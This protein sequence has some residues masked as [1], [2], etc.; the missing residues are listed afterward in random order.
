MS[1][2]VHIDTMEQIDFKGREVS[3]AIHIFDDNDET[4]IFVAKGDIDCDDMDV[5]RNVIKAKHRHDIHGGS[6][7]V[8][9]DILDFI[10]EN[11]KGVTIAN[12]FYD[13]KDIAE[14]MKYDFREVVSCPDCGWESFDSDAY[15]QPCMRDG[16]EGTMSKTKMEEYER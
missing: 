15:D 16:C 12:T 5:L 10:E 14:V 6:C 1:N 3:Y 9:E 8:I 11:T 2:R 7:Q 4:T 13:Y